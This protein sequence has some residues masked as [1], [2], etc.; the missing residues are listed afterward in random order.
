[1]DGPS[2]LASNADHIDHQSAWV[3]AWEEPE[4]LADIACAAGMLGL[5]SG[6]LAVVGHAGTH[7]PDRLFW[8]AV[9]LLLIV[10]PALFLGALCAPGGL[11]EGGGSA[12]S[13][14][15]R[16]GLSGYASYLAPVVVLAVAAA[17]ASVR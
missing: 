14:V 1:M 6:L 2:V 12:W 8:R 7:F 4:A 16:L 11:L 9:P 17:A 5:F 15:A 13:R 3:S 10:P